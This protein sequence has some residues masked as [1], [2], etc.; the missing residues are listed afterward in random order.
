MPGG[1]RV[2][3]GSKKRLKRITLRGNWSVGFWV[4]VLGIL[5]ALFV[6]APT[7]KEEVLLTQGNYQ[8]MLDEE[9]RTYENRIISFFL[10]NLPP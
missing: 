3:R 6:L 7:P 4:F 2:H 1:G 5:I 9:K 8:G 10:L